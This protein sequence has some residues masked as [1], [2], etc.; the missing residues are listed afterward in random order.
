MCTYMIV[1]WPDLKMLKVG[2]DLQ[3]LIRI[4]IKSGY[5]EIDSQMNI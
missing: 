3:I 4:L 5:W 1:H 2:K